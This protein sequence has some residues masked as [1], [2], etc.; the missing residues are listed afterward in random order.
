MPTQPSGTRQNSL[1]KDQA[2]ASTLLLWDNKG[3]PPAKRVLRNTVK[4]QSKHMNLYTALLLSQCRIPSKTSYTASNGS[5]SKCDVI[6]CD[7][8]NYAN[9]YVTKWYH[10]TLYLLYQLLEFC[11]VFLIFLI[12]GF[13]SRVFSL[14]T[15][16]CAEIQAPAIVSDWMT[17]I[18]AMAF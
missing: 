17:R 7:L 4:L 11:F 12:G 2:K 6:N 8:R 18:L 1:R 13:D 9:F 5:R 16:T 3:E 10:N 14:V 15:M